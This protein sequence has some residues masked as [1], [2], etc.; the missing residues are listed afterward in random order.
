MGTSSY[1]FITALLNDPK[2]SA[3]DRDRIIQLIGR[4]LERKNK[5]FVTEDRLKD[6]VT[7]DRLKE[8]FATYS[9]GTP[10]AKSYS[11]EA[12][13]K[14][15]PGS[16]MHCPREIVHFLKL[17]SNSSS[18]L[19][20]TTHTWDKTSETDFAY[21]SYDDFIKQCAADFYEKYRENDNQNRIYKCNQSLYFLVR[22]FLFRDKDDEKYKGWGQYN[23]K[24][25]YSYPPNV[26]KTWM[27]E[28]P[29]K[30]PGSM[31]LS[32]FPHDLTQPINKQ[33]KRVLGYFEDIGLLFKK[34]IQFRE[35]DLYNNVKRIFSSSDFKVNDE[36]LETLKGVEFY[37]S[38]WSFK[39]ALT[40]VKQNITA[41][42]SEH[43]KVEIWAEVHDERDESEKYV[44]IC[45][46]QLGSYSDKTVNDDK[47]M[48][49]NGMGQIADIKKWLVSLCDFHVESR[50]KI[51]GENNYARIDYLKDTDI[52]KEPEVLSIDKCDGF[53]YCFRFYL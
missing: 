51:N 42:S 5:D 17:F 13:V 1:K 36:K 20:Y 45:I 28:N 43:N 33:V 9:V 30:Q 41:R 12:Q 44:D 31:P 24:I 49:R 47:L 53:K 50:F 48:L 4:E 8:L 34:E 6:F 26:L 19:K 23:V 35:N 37:T 32:I 40:I 29:G 7:M 21:T 18:A 14:N 22:N 27:D 3:S 46:D 15:E 2:L 11:A 38:T 39:T 25:G 10:E 16:T 52:S